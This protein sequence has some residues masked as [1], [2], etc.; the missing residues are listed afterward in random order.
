MTLCVC[1]EL[2]QVRGIVDLAQFVM[3]QHLGRSPQQSP[4]LVLQHHL[5]GIGLR[6]G[7]DHLLED[8]ARLGHPRHRVR[9]SIDVEPED[10]AHGLPGVGAGPRVVADEAHALRGQ[11][12]PDQ[13]HHAVAD[14]LRRPRIEAVGDHVVERLVPQVELEQ[15]G[16]DEPDV[17]QAEG[18]HHLLP[19]PDRFDRQV[20]ADE[21]GVGMDQRKRDDVCAVA[22]ADV[23]HPAPGRRRDRHPEQGAVSPQPGR[24][25]LAERGGRI[26]HQVIGRHRP[27]HGRSS[28]VVEPPV[29]RP[30]ARNRRDVSSITPPARA[31]RSPRV[32][33]PAPQ[34]RR[35]GQS[36]S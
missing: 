3:E 34:G 33:P 20:E 18:V 2:M 26:R 5:V 32:P 8:P 7:V 22:A 28:A 29:P 9:D 11:P 15:V 1:N 19:S 14:R 30:Q 21:L 31:R 17:F 25:R 4:A 6:V 36:R 27:G 10:A 13:R 23:Q 16:R 24:M 35:R 12:P